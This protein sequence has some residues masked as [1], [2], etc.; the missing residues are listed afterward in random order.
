MKINNIKIHNFRGINECNIIFPT[1]QRIVCIIGPGDSCKSTLLKAIEWSL[2]PS[3]NLSIT[4]LDFYK[5]N[6]NSPIVIEST[7][8]ELP[9]DITNEDKYG[10]Y[11]RDLDSVINNL[12]NDEPKEGKPVVITIK[13]VID[14]TLEP[15]WTVIN[16]RS[17]PR[18]ISAKDRRLLSFG[19]VGFDYEKDFLWGRGS[20]L[21]KYQNSS[22]ETLHTA[23]TKAMRFAVEN[24]DLS[25]LDRIT[26]DITTI[27]AR[28]GVSFNGEL[29]NKIIMQNGSYSTSVGV[30][31]SDVPFSQRGLGSKRLLSMGLNINVLSDGTLILID[32]IETGLEPY[33]ICTLINQLRSE[34]SNKGQIIFSTHSRSV[35]CECNVDELHVIVEH[36]GSVSLASL[37]NNDTKDEVQAIIRTEPDSFLCK[38]LIVCEGKTEIGL[39][40]AFDSYNF[41]V[42]N[43]RFA[44]YGVGTALGG[45]GSKAFKLAELL[46]SCGY[47]VS[48]FMDADI[49]AE[50]EE[51]ERMITLGIPVFTWEDSN[52]V[53]EQIFTDVNLENAEALLALACESKTYDSVITKLNEGFKEDNRPYYSEAE[54]IRLN[55][56]ITFEQRKAIGTIAKNKKCE[57]FKRIDLGEKVGEIV[58]SEYNKMDTTTG[59]KSTIEKLNKW[60][61]DH[62]D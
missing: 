43:T 54:M 45:G 4:D 12:E 35:V 37:S 53:E 5:G 8:S 29:H 31:D 15:I 23:Y 1:N 56:D 19:L 7:I 20:V 16:N 44:H 47:D 46:N 10:L 36:E 57:W 48:I 49:S 60:V 59:F 38:R 14:D 58:F 51:M 13:L 9:D 25:E 28:Y 61:T 11:L 42:N 27:G 41:A 2:W 6:T 22:K 52:A 26:T 3:A 18:L 21:Q 17:E 24:T 30:F 33:R 62:E 39:L 34:Y 55:K 40:R 32:E 50:I